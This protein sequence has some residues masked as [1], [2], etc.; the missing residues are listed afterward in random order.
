MWVIFHFSAQTSEV[1]SGVSLRVT[2]RIASWLHSTFLRNTGE[3]EL[4]ERMH[5]YIRKFAHMGE[6]GILFILLFLSFKVS[7]KAYRCMMNGI[8]ISF[9]YACI[10][11]FHQTFVSGRSG[12]FADVC[13][14]MTGVLFAILLILI[15][16]APGQD[17]S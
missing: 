2:R 6:Y 17:N 1:S 9:I 5:P 15:F 8:L 3:A 16:L 12:Q 11:E 10:D 14:D 4:V 7:F 13:V